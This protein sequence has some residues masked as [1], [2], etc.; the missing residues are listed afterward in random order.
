VLNAIYAQE[1]RQGARR[2][3]R[4][5]RGAGYDVR[6]LVDEFKD[7]VWVEDVLFDKLEV[8]QMGEV[9]GEAGSGRDGESWYES[10][11]HV[12]L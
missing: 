7:V 12:A 1:R 9:K 8:M 11:Q 10:V 2:S 3:S 5:T 4:R 6:G